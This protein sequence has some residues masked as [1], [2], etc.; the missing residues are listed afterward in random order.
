MRKIL[1]RVALAVG[2][3]L[4]VALLIPVARI[5]LYR[6]ADDPEHLRLKRAYLERVAGLAGDLPRGPNLVLILFDDL[7]YGDIG[8]YG[9]T[10]IRTPNLD[11]IA[12]RGA[13]FRHAYAA[14]PYCSAS[15][16]GLLTGRYAVR[17][18]MDHVL[19]PAGTDKNLLIRLGWL[20][21]RLP[22]EEITIAE[23]LSAAGYATAAFGKWHLGARSPSL[24]NDMG[25][26]S[27]YGLL[28]SNDQGTPEVRENDRIVERHPID[29]TTLTRRYTER[30]VAFIE[31]HAGR[32]FFLYLPHT[33]P[34]VPLHVAGERLGRSEAGLYGDVVEELDESVGAV[35]DALER[36]GV[37][38][39]TLVLVTSDNG[40]WF[41]GSPGGVR[42]RK[43][44]VF[45]GGMRVPLLAAW[46]GRVPAGHVIDVP[47]VGVDVFPTVLELTGVPGP[48]DRVIDGQSL[49]G[50]LDGGD[51]ARR[52]PVYYHRISAL[53]AVREGRFKY[54]ARHG[55]F[56]GNP[57]D[58]T[59]GPMKRRG[60]WLFDLELD[61]DESY[62]VSDRYPA[63]AGRL[64]GVLESRRRELA[65]NPRG[66][67]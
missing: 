19:Q 21:T 7:G 44:D 24:P 46:P 58:W 41:Q 17:S 22:A 6:Q 64:R 52:E 38:Q 1:K 50:L 30:A 34:H 63:I 51:W 10:A 28:Y 4:A 33:F 56:Y 59:W 55:V 54:H 67:Y 31:S 9:G 13:L 25:F 15:R 5:A 26:D 37:A 45:E 40:P 39:D 12:A 61:P 3:L 62:D 47:A 35:I 42:G 11:R 66:W 29:Q 65:D 36:T 20:N 43:M 8:V 53:Q 27:Y 2:L 18:G 16:A 48:D 23:V 57:M 49:V 14:S 60:P 32:P